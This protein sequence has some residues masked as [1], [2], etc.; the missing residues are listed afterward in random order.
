MS[1]ARAPRAA[2]QR[3]DEGRRHREQKERKYSRHALFEA[4]KVN[5]LL[6]RSTMMPSSMR[7]AKTSKRLG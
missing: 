3:C 5:K 2:S 4:F 1:D 6:L 7:C